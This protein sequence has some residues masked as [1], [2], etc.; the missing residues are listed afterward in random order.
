M[1]KNLMI[2]ASCL[3]GMVIVIIIYE[4]SHEPHCDEA[5]VFM[6]KK[7]LVRKVKDHRYREKLIF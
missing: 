3:T 7:R 1:H 5:K 6:I 4:H 2:L